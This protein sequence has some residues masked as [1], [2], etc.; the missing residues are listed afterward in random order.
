MCD[1]YKKTLA[2]I[3]LRWHTQ[4]WPKMYAVI[5]KSSTLARV[6]ENMNFTDFQLS[7][8]EMKHINS[9]DKH[10]RCC[11][12]AEFWNIPLFE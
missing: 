12:S 3:L 4:K 10:Q 8:D 11:D 7:D 9:L 5:P 6:S 2:Q 1:K